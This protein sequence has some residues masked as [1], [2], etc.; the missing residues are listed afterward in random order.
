MKSV[1]LSSGK[2]FKIESLTVAQSKKHFFT[3]EGNLKGAD[4]QIEAAFEIL[5]A[6]L[7]NA[8]YHNLPLHKRI[9]R[10]PV[11][12]SYLENHLSLSEFRE[13]QDAVI[14]ISGLKRS[15]DEGEAP[16]AR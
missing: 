8:T 12:A 15:S 10:R 4:E 9:F 16:A 1:T 2:E 13:L 11:T 14:E 7:N 5:A 3:A 6:S